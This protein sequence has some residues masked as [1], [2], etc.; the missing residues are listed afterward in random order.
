MKLKSLI[1][2][3]AVTGLLAWSQASAEAQVSVNSLQWIEDTGNYLLGAVN[4][5]GGPVVYGLPSYASYAN[6]T[7][8]LLT[9]QVYRVPSSALSY[10][11]TIEIQNQ[12]NGSIVYYATGLSFASLTYGIDW[13]EDGGSKHLYTERIYKE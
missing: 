1:L 8:Y 11:C 12:T 4:L 6:K 13:Y 3:L 2:A 10:K 9:L 7:E 5:R